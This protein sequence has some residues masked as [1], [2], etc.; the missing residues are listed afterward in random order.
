MTTGEFAEMVQKMR[1]AQKN[2]FR[3]KSREWLDQSR[4][5]EVQ[6]DMALELRSKRETERQNPSLFGGEK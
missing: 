5:W 2:Y 4:K 1:T 3:T 6:V